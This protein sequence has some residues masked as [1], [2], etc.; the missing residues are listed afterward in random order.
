MPSAQLRSWE[1]TSEERAYE[2][3]R[4]GKACAWEKNEWILDAEFS[5]LGKE[6]T[7]RHTA[8]LILFM[9]KY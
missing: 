6:H 5:I 7:K 1:E 9:S 8:S 2:G 3:G 4:Q